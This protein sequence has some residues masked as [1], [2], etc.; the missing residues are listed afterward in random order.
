VRWDH[1]E[2]GLLG[3][4]EFVPLAEETGLIVPIGRW[5][6]EEACHRTKGW[7]ESHPGSAPLAV[8]VNF[9]AAQLRDPGCVGD[10]EQVLQRSGLWPGALGLDVTESAF[11][12][13]L[14][15]NAGALS[16]IKGMGVRISI[17]DFGTGYSSLSYLKRLPADA[18]KIDKSFVGGLGKHPDDTAIVRMTVELAHTLGME[19]IAEGV[20]R[21]AQA[22]ILRGMGCDLAQ[23]FLFSEPLP[24]EKIS[25][26]IS[27][28]TPD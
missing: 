5:V 18:I 17:D 7:Q 10:I 25:A 23:G 19:V 12:D 16:L 14:E 28:D 24:L 2:R 22:E 27:S 9:S 11:I 26:L 4:S 13:T 15:G 1:P 20:E 3:P 21:R 8:I 6:L